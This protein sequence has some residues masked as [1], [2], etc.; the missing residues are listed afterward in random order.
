MEKLTICLWFDGNGEEAARFY[1]DLFAE[2]SIDS[3]TRSPADYPAGKEGDVLTVNFTL[4]DRS[5]LALNG[6]PFTAFN[7]AISLSIDCEDQAEVDRY[8]AALSHHP[9]KEQCGWVK[10]KFGLSWQIVPRR[11]PE[12]LSGPDA[13]K[14]KRVMEAMMS[15]KKIDVA[16]LEQAAAG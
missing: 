15:M 8:W 2:S 11:L 13:A 16:E 10:D 9:E 6:G 14:A 12:L 3:I 5:F 4:A 1:V 7:E